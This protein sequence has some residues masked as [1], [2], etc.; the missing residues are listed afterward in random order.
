MTIQLFSRLARWTATA[1]IGLASLLVILPASAQTAVPSTA[2]GAKSEQAQASNTIA[3]IASS[4][5]SFTTLT[6]LLQ[7]LGVVGALN[8]PNG[9]DYTIFAPTDAAFAAV[10]EETINFLLSD[11]GRETLFDILSYHALPGSI[12]SSQLRSGSFTSTNGLPLKVDLT[13]GVKVNGANVLQ[14]DIIASNGVIH[15]IDQVLIPKR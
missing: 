14:A 5:S 12:T 1:G 2:A 11:E 6:M 9:E 8:N 15:V 3:A 10:P 7:H 13:Q 4:N